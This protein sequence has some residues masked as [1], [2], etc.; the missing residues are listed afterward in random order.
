MARPRISTKH[1]QLDKANQ[2]VIVATA[3]AAVVLVFGFFMG[4]ALVQR[5]SHQA[6]VIT[7]KETARE[8][9]KANIEAKDQLVQAYQVFVTTEKNLL[10]GN[11]NSSATG[12]RDGDNGSLILDALPSKYDFPALATSV[13]KLLNGR[14]YRLSGIDGVDDEINQSLVQA[15]PN[16]EPVEMPI[17]FTVSTTYEASKSM[18]GLFERSIR[19][20]KISAINI[21]A[22]E[23]SLELT[24][25]AVTYYQPEKAISI[26]KEVIK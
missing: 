23:G 3:I 25:N 15:M 26:T 18:L 13:E 2:V 4:R 16:P 6:R 24:I 9:L 5:Q 12:D 21:A 8:Q 20:F 17:S 19:P 7:A 1:I 14:G 22:Q 10:G 11:P